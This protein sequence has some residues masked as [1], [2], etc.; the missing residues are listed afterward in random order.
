MSESKFNAYA[1]AIVEFEEEINRVKREIADDS[2][3][4]I[5]LSDLYTSELRNIA[6]KSLSEI[7]KLINEEKERQLNSIR[8]QY[9]EE[10]ERQLNSIRKEAEKNLDKAVNVVIRQLLGVFK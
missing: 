5:T 7:Q 6:E 4:I 9:A 3:K 10:R 8:S 2:K 1:K